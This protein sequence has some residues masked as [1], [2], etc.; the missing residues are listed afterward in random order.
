MNELVTTLSPIVPELIV[1]I[2][3]GVVI[4]ADGLLSRAMGRT[5]LPIITVV[6][7]LAALIT[8]TGF[9][10]IWQFPSTVT[11]TLG[12]GT[13]GFGAFVLIDDFTNYFRALFLLLAI[14]GTVVAPNYLY[15]KQ[16]PPGE[17]YATV[18]F[19]TLGS[20][21][22]A[23][24]TDLI[25]IFVGIELMTIPMYVLAG[26]QRRDRFSNEAALKYFLLG[27]FSSALLVYGFAW[28][29]GI[30]GATRFTEIA[31]A[32]RVTGLANGATIIALSLITVG[33]GFKAAVVPFHQWT[34]RSCVSWSAA[35][36]RSRSTGRRSSPCLPR[37]R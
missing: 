12:S 31:A 28:L 11:L 17:F 9:V 18:L 1:T 22:I 8:P 2:T 4:V 16:V 32:L 3:A 35:W 24:S 25:T 14:F 34:P 20:M 7:L 10:Q 30:T 5:W 6:G 27:A 21:T 36:G 15:R 23:L 33:L 26:I 37:S 13:P 19:S 29:F